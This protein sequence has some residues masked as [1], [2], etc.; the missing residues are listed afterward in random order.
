MFDSRSG[1]DVHVLYG[2]CLAWQLRNGE[3]RWNEQHHYRY[4]HDRLRLSVHRCIRV[5][6]VS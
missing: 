2:L 4:G 1:V 5:Y 6:L 3:P